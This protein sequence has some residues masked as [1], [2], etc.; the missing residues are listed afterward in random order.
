MMLAEL[1]C[2]FYMKTWPPEKYFNSMLVK[3]DEHFTVNNLFD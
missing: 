3:L 1:W 2:P